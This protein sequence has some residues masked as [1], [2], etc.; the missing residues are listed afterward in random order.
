MYKALICHLAVI[1]GVV[2]VCHAD[3]CWDKSYAQTCYNIDAYDY[4]EGTS[5]YIDIC[6]NGQEK[7]G[8]Y[9]SETPCNVFGCGCRCIGSKEDPKFDCNNYYNSRSLL[10][11][12]V[13]DD[14]S[15]E[16]MDSSELPSAILACQEKM[17]SKFNTSS[18]TTA[19]QIN[20]YFNCLDTDGDGTLDDGD[21]SVT[22]VDDMN[23][24]SLMGDTNKDGVIQ[25]EE[26]DSKI[27]DAS[28]AT[29][30]AYEM[31]S[32]R[33]VMQACV[34]AAGVGVLRRVLQGG[35]ML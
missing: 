15:N 6:K 24:G 20:E 4:D 9:C 7:K 13:S 10:S 26:F 21:A 28:I 5:S 16:P 19:S 27:S 25:P 2:A 31:G 17:T 1:V 14:T 29:S 23:L 18:L 35:D 8:F 34:A 22:Q 3:C 30:D 33:M 11:D 12:E 32:A